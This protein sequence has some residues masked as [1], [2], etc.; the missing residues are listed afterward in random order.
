MP[1]MTRSRVVLPAPLCPMRPMRSPCSR[2][3]DTPSSATISLTPVDDAPIRP[4]VV[5]RRT[6]DLSDRPPASKMGKTT[7]TSRT[8]TDAISDPVG[9]ATTIARE[10][11]ERQREPD[12]GYRERGDP[13]HCVGRLAEHRRT[14]DRDQMVKWIERCELAVPRQLIGTPQDRRQ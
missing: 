11:H 1:A 14:H 2:C 12:G 3:S 5:A 10:H 6:C 7:E 13:A 4:P 9:D 8:S